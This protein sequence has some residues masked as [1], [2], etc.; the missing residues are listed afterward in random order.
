MPPKKYRTISMPT[1][2]TDVIEKL[3]E[4]LRYWPSVGAFCREACLEKID[5]INEQRK[6]QNEREG[7]SIE[8]KD[9]I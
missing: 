7:T 4:E 1:G 3:I 2:I 9:E 6:L 8:D 5:K